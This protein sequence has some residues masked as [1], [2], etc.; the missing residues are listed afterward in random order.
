MNKTPLSKISI[1]T[2]GAC[3]PNPGPGGWGA[4]LLR[5]GQKPQ[6]LAGGETETTNNRMELTAAIEAITFLSEPHQVEIFTDSKYV[7]NGITE[8]LPRWQER[9]WQ[10]VEQTAV[11]NKDLWQALARKIQIHEIQWRWLKG[12][13]D[14]KWNERADALARAEVKNKTSLPLKD[15]QSI[16]IFTA[17]SY[18]TKTKTGGWSVILRYRENIKVLYGEMPNTTGNRMHLQAAIEGLSAIKRALPINLYTY[19]GY[20]KDGATQ[21]VKQW[22]KTDWQTREGRPVQHRD[23]WN[24][25]N[26]FTQKYQ[27]QWHVADKANPPCEMQEVKLL[28]GEILR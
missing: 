8:W 24:R 20:L 22:S 5:D 2:D 13:N 25:L 28:A 26:G 11:K 1:Y 14:N 16:H 6:E 27:I 3:S 18:K 10:T 7:K 12:H 21:W 15:D 19:S 4:I 17:V 23:L 9:N